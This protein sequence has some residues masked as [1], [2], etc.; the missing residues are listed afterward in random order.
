MWPG[1]VVEDD[2]DTYLEFPFFARTENQNR[3]AR[4][5]VEGG[6]YQGGW[7]SHNLA[8]VSLT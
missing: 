4:K 1:L 6:G 7:W 3:L 2:L 8:V 5:D